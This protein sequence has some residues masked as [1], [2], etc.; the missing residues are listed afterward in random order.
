[1]DFN[2]RIQKRAAGH[3]HGRVLLEIA[4]RE[5]V[6]QDMLRRIRLGE[7]PVT[8]LSLPLVKAIGEIDA[9]DD[10]LRRLAGEVTAAVVEGQFG[11]LRT[12]GSKVIKDDLVFASGQ[13]FKEGPVRR[14]RAEAGSHERGSDLA[15]A[16]VLIKLLGDDNLSAIE[17]LVADE[18][19]RRAA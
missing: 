9:Q 11:C 7:K 16:E 4:S 8:A 6:Q 2:S 3:R 14:S 18:L 5:E 12:T 19:H 10:S 13:P 17:G 1:M 15:V